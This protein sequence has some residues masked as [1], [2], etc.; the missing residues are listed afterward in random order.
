MPSGEFSHAYYS[1]ADLMSKLFAVKGGVGNSGMGAYH[2]KASFL[3]FSHSKSVLQRD[4]NRI[5]EMFA[6]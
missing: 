1:D 3:T 6:K 4:Y 5:A 2:G